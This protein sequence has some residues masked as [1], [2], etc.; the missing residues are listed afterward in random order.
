M[1]LPDPAPG[2]TADRVPARPDCDKPDGLQ[3]PVR[4]APIDVLAAGAVLL[5]AALWAV[6]R[7]GPGKVPNVETFA[8]FASAWPNTDL[9]KENAYLLREPL[10]QAVYHLFFH[11][12]NTN[13][14][15]L[16]HLAA[17]VA[18][19]VVLLSWFCLELGP[20]RGLIAGSVV[21]L[22]PLA[23]VQ[24]KW[25]GIYDAFSLLAWLPMIFA[26]WRGRALQLAGGVLAGLQNFEQVVVATVLLLLIRPLTDRAGARPRG[27]Y[28]LGGALAGKAVLELYLRHVDAV[29][30]NRF[31][32]LKGQPGYLRGLMENGALMAPVIVFSAL[33]G[34][35]VFVIPALMSQ[36]PAW[37]ASTRCQ[38]VAAAAIWYLTQYITGDHTRVMAMTSF[39]AL[40]VGAFVLA[41][42]SGGVRAV[43]RS[44]AWWVF[45][46]VQPVVVFDTTLLQLGIA[47][48][49]FGFWIF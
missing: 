13:I 41:R 43:V 21:M 24:M 8:V 1:S 44:P 20:E 48:G 38:V 7:A 45:A 19:A 28:L 31:T 4:S 26:L 9:P 3:K 22:A 14:F 25:I 39:P 18:A 16:L 6:W 46:A 42:D 35:W 36:W 15:V 40:V 12:T 17:L 34:L 33:A 23:A 5:I 10:G 37:G 47:R 32:F 30:G 49:T 11:T 27:I 2:V 29:S